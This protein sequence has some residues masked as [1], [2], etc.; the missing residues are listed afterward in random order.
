MILFDSKRII[1]MWSRTIR[2]KIHAPRDLTRPRPS[3][4]LCVRLATIAGNR[5]VAR[6][7]E[8]CGAYIRK[9][10]EFVKLSYYDIDTRS[11]PRDPDEDS[12]IVPSKRTGIMEEMG[13]PID[14]GANR[15][16][17]LIHDL[18]LVMKS[19]MTK[20]NEREIMWCDI[21]SKCEKDIRRIVNDAT[22]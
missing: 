5:P 19:A 17:A 18:I 13:E 12:R 16:E 9:I 7:K 4:Y 20:V 8:S 22:Q 11:Q 15:K 3:I 1:G 10:G 21:I 2:S 14:I 6:R